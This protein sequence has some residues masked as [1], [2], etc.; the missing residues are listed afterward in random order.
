MGKFASSVDVPAVSTGSQIM[1]NLTNLI[2]SFAMGTTILLGQQIGSGKRREGGKTVAYVRICGGGM[3]VI[4]AYNLVGCIFRGL[5][6]SKTP[7]LTV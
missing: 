1:M 5:G 4:V 2:S 3:L 6:D 7:L